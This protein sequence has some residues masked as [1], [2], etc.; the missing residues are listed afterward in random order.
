M[1]RSE[2]RDDGPPQGGFARI[3]ETMKTRMGRF[4]QDRARS[5]TGALD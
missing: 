1:T 3:Q 5:D 4:F 2:T